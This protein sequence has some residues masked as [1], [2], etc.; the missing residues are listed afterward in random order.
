MCDGIAADD[1]ARAEFAVGWRFRDERGASVAVE[2]I[3]AATSTHLS[4][5]ERSEA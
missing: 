1:F 4:K 2:R 5:A 3:G